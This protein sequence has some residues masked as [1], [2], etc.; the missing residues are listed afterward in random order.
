MD[1]RDVCFVSFENIFLSL[2]KHIESAICGY[3][4]EH[5]RGDS[6]LEAMSK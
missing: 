6:T 5:N 3:S 2:C 1:V 4:N